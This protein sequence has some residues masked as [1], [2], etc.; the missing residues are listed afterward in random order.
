MFELEVLCEI[1]SALKSVAVCLTSDGWPVSRCSALLGD[2]VVV[3]YLSSSSSSRNVSIATFISLESRSVCRSF[4][5]PDPLQ[6]S[7]L[8]ESIVARFVVR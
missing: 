8:L 6:R 4:T 7:K 3:L 1:V 5:P 2:D